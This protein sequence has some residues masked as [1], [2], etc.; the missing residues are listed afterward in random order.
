MHYYNHKLG[1]SFEFLNLIWPEILYVPRESSVISTY[2]YVLNLDGWFGVL[3]HKFI[4]FDITLLYC[5]IILRSSITFCLSAGHTSLSLG[6]SLSC[7]FVTIFGFFCSESFEAFVILLV[8]LL[9]TKSPVAS[10][11]FWISLF[12]AAWRA[13]DADFLAWLRGFWLS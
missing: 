6:I 1:F 12:E 4:T 5:Y 10:A 11:A 13:S 7:L 8:I 9:P 2:V 3:S